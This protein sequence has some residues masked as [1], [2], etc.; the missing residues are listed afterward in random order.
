MKTQNKFWVAALVCALLLTSIGNAQEKKPSYKM[1]ELTYIMPK[2]G[3]EQAFVKAI[4][5]HDNM[6]HKSGPSAAHLEYIVTGKEAGWYVWVMGPTTFTD[7]DNRPD[8]GAHADDWN[9]NVSPN[10]A[11][12]GRVEYWKMN[13]KLSYVNTA[14]TSRSKYETIW[15]V[16]VTRGQYYRFKAFMTKIKE[17]YVKKGGTDDMFIY[18][19]QFTENNGRDVAIVWPFNSWADLDKDDGG[20][21]KTFED[22]NGE[23]SWDNAMKDWAEFTQGMVSQVW[24]VSVN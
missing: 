18:E 9:K 12:Y 3:M 24:D 8:K 5:A 19:N 20:I 11:K 10:V 17:A 4:T 14:N 1:V 16:D 23:G 15:A 13:D 2:I 7:L 6:Y 21:K 22:I